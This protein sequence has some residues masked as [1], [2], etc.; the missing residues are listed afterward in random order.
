MPVSQVWWARDAADRA[1]FEA[2]VGRLAGGVLAG[3]RYFHLDLTS[4]SDELREGARLVPDGKEWLDPPWRERDHDLLDWGLEFDTRDGR[5][6]GASWYVNPYESL[7]FR[8]ERLLETQLGPS[9]SVAIWDVTHTAGWNDYVGRR[10]SRVQV[11][12]ERW[13]RETFTCH[14]V[15]LEFDAA[16]IVVGAEGDS[17]G[18]TFGADRARLRAVGPYS[19][20]EEHFDVT[21]RERMSRLFRPN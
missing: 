13:D 19:P 2:R 1:A 16:T 3:V 6:F 4:D 10:V 14:A 20:R 17:I 7:E 15:V 5:T 8:E 11:C 9:A 12:W 21:L 18:V